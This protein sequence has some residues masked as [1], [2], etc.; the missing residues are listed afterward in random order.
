M[1][2]KVS[3][4]IAILFKRIWIIA[5]LVLLGTGG[6]FAVSK[7]AI[8]KEYTA[9]VTMYVAPNRDNPDIFASLSDLNY[10]Q[11][12]INTY[13]VILETNNFLRTVAD[14]SGLDY[15]VKELKDMI[16]MKPVEDTEIFEIS[17]TSKNPRHSLILA[18]TITETAPKRIIEIKNAD[19][20]RAVDPAILPEKPSAPKLLLNTAIG[21]ILGLAA[22]VIAAFLLERLDKRINEEEDLRSGYDE[23]IL[24]VIPLMEGK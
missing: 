7:Y 2:Y 5:L 3:E 14:Q 4:V 6:T 24:G 21:F 19:A 22:G 1:E 15:S 17:V 16:K 8:D 10:A 13:I 23:P 20:V 12:V 18:D 9:T 11:E